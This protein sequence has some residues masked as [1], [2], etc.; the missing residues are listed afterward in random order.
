V[1]SKIT[2]DISQR[3]L[4]RMKALCWMMVVIAVICRT[5]VQCRSIDT[6]ETTPSTV[7]EEKALDAAVNTAAEIMTVEAVGEAVDKEMESE[8]QRA[9]DAKEQAIAQAM[10]AAETEA[11]KEILQD[12]ANQAEVS[13]PPQVPIPS[14][15]F[16]A[17]RGDNEN[18]IAGTRDKRTIGAITRT[19]SCI[20]TILVNPNC[21]N[22]LRN[23]RAGRAGGG[24]LFGGLFG[25]ARSS[26]SGTSSRQAAYNRQLRQ[27][28]EYQRRQISKL[29]ATE[30]G[31]YTTPFPILP[32]QP[33]QED[34]EETTQR[35]GFLSQVI[36][37]KLN[38]IPNLFRTIRSLF[39][40]ILPFIQN[41]GSGGG[42]GGGGF[43]NLLGG[44]F[45]G[46]GGGSSGGFGSSGGS[47]SYS[48]SRYRPS[49]SSSAL[50]SSSSSTSGENSLTSG[51]SG[52]SS[53]SETSTYRISLG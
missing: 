8:V 3:F 43:G 29:N 1:T 10:K 9:A 53:P 32:P 13:K 16:E 35:P 12:A 50:S 18:A 15:A 22:E 33:P 42:S 17:G 7:E 23:E 11:I 30:G 36:Q 45:G 31:N 47:S 24:G 19:A 21:F 34:E 39:S 27:W 14:L 6:A 20:F 4:S 44:L 46:G 48:S 51:S 2:R 49:S 26:S 40:A 28:I 5:E 37:F 52:G 38:L 41:L 25:G